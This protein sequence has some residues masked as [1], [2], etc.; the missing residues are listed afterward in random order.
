M[1]P[2][3]REVEARQSENRRGTLT[4]ARNGRPD[5]EAPTPAIQRRGRATKIRWDN[6][7]KAGAKTHKQR[8]RQLEAE[9][10]R[11][12]SKERPT[13]AKHT[14]KTRGSRQQAASRQQ[15]GEAAAGAGCG[16]RQ[17]NVIGA[18][19]EQRRWDGGRDTPRIIIAG[20]AM[21]TYRESSSLGWRR[22]H[23]IR[24]EQSP[25][26]GG[27]GTPRIIIAGMAMRTY[28]GPS[29][30]GW[31]RGH[32]IRKEPPSLG[33]RQRHTQDHRRWDGGGD[34]PRAIVAGMAAGDT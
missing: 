17:R 12:G 13:S 3:G 15:H 24:K 26:D 4:A 19:R 22:G 18:H 33:W 14:K 31:R 5:G 21:G 2:R 25:Q 32:R 6:G 29:S 34:L 20:M 27:R 28:R 16:P 23:R 11:A 7:R 30:L 9:R 8:R 10:R 1:Q